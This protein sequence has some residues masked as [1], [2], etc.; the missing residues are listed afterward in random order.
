MAGPRR[1]PFG[2]LAA[3]MLIAVT[4]AACGNSTA[5]SL[6]AVPNTQND[7]GGNGGGNSLA[8]GLSSN[9]DNLDSYQFTVTLFG[10]SSGATPASGGA[11]G[12]TGTVVNKPVKAVAIDEYGAQYI[13]IGDKAWTSNDGVSWLPS[14][15][16][17]SSMIDF[18]PARDYATWFDAYAS[19]FTV[20]GEETKNGVDCIRYKGA[21]ALSQLFQAAGGVAANFESDVWI[22]KNGNY[23][24][25]GAFGFGQTS[26]QGLQFDISNINDPANKV[27]QPAN[28]IALPT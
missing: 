14:D 2:V 10:R 13:V 4:V 17:S 1:K 15:P 23:P 21:P 6:P 5:P 28:I 19:S 11:G 8:V 20:S 26:G 9:L 7:G 25:S 22:A 12:I 16:G 24:V 18:L 27:T 3:G